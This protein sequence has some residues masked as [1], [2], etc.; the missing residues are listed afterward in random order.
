MEETKVVKKTWG[1]KRPGAGRPKGSTKPGGKRK[2]CSMAAYPDEWEMIKEFS[3]IVKYD[4]PT[5]DK[6]MEKYRRNKAK[7]E[8]EK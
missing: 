8:Q 3:R 4:R 1:G 7:K 2:G 6:M 5:A